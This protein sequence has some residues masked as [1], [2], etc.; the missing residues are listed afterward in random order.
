VKPEEISYTRY[1]LA[2]A[3]ETLEEARTL[4]ETQQLRGA[5]NRLYYACFYAVTALLFTEGRHSSKHTGIRSMFMKDWI[6]AGRLPVRMGKFYLRLFDYRMKGDYHI[7]TLFHQDELEAW[8]QEAKD[9]IAEVS[10]LI[11]QQPCEDEQEK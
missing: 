8:F 2:L 9:F 4:V 3:N 10:T 6:H 7:Q 11:E 1:R 5:V